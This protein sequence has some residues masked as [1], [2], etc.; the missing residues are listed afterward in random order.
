MKTNIQKN[1]IEI[2]AILK[3]TSKNLKRFN[4][5]LFKIS[6]D[7]NV[8]FNDMLKVAR[9][10]ARQGLSTEDVLK[11]SKDALILIT[12]LTKTIASYENKH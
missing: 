4:E 1:L 3:S 9:D 11:R 12:Y 6:K 10:F 5:N 2:N 7:T 8:A